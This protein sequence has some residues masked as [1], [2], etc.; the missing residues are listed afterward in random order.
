[1]NLPNKLTI[2]RICLVPVICALLLLAQPG[3]DWMIYA[4]AVLFIIASL[5]DLF[6]G[7]IAR[8]TGQVTNFGKF[9]DP[10]ADKLLVCST[11]VCF[12]AR[13]EAPAWA[14]LLIMAREFAISGFRLIAVEKGVV[15]AASQ[16]GKLKT[17]IQTA[18]IIG[19]LFPFEWNVWKVATQILMWAA[20]ILTIWSFADYIYHNKAVLKE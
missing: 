5:T 4:A 16:L 19:L 6:D 14:F 12:V 1:M 3:G 7:K 17:N 18:W 8:K 2:C 15:L 11:L 20:V 9:M 10:L 13:G